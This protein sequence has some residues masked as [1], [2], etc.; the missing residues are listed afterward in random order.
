MSRN[1]VKARNRTTLKNTRDGVVQR[2]EASGEDIQI[3][4]RDDVF[5]LRGQN[6]DIPDAPYSAGHQQLSPEQSA[7][8][9]QAY[10]HKKTVAEYE[11]ESGSTQESERQ[12]SQT[13]YSQ[14][15]DALPANAHNTDTTQSTLTA[16]D[17]L[18]KE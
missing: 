1:K 18:Y 6:E 12:P 3:S 17:S 15:D 4:K 9:R 8:H 10:R 2:N 5:D 11:L 7:K 14:S 13:G 16:D